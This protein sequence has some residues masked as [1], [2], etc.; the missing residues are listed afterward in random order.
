MTVDIHVRRPVDSWDDYALRIMLYAK[1]K[2]ATIF[3]NDRGDT[4][5]SYE[6]GN[7]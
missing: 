2:G 3:V 1:K 5:V 7:A 6:E 4:T